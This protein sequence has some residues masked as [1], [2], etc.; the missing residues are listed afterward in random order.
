[1]GWPR[2]RQNKK[3]EMESL[4][5]VVV[6]EDDASEKLTPNMRAL[7][8]AMTAGDVLLGMG[9]PASRVVSRC[10][11]ITEA[12]TRQSV[13]V[14]VN[15]NL[16]MLS[17]LR[18]VDKEPL[19]LI[20]PV[21]ERDVNNMTIQLVQQLIHKI[22]DDKLNLSDAEAELD[23]IL[24]NPIV[25]PGWL[26][27]SARASIAAGVTL[28]FTNSLAVVLVTFVIA[29]MVDRLLGLLRGWGITRFFSIVGAAAFV[30]MAAALIKLLSDNNISFFAG[31][32][33]TLIVVGGI[34]MLVAGLM[35]VGA[36]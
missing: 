21:V 12:Y 14:D 22:R 35:I 36:I 28:M 30:T 19:T 6:H 27:T 32:N 13:H 20:R 33:P 17:Q 34:I 9:V 16:I 26:T 31:M 4:G 23:N 7:R 15:S 25:Y 24:N 3:V 29:V 18:G 11:D 1:M 2:L 8:L 10:L 5:N